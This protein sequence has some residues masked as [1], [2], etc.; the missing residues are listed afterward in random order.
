MVPIDV[1]ETE[2][3]CWTMTFHLQMCFNLRRHVH[4]V[5]L[6]IAGEDCELCGDTYCFYSVLRH[7][8]YQVPTYKREIEHRKDTGTYFLIIGSPKI[9][10]DLPPSLLACWLLSLCRVVLYHYH[11]DV[12]RCIIIRRRLQDA[13]ITPVMLC[14]FVQY[15][16]K[17]R[18]LI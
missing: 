16:L 17:N 15:I 8:W 7:Q 9:S 5:N 6:G 1:R 3:L 14:L 4:F 2:L 12:K 11:S 10:W 18:P 13:Q